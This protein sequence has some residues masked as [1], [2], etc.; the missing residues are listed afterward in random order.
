MGLKRLR[1]SLRGAFRA[2]RIWRS[3]LTLIAYLWWDA[4]EWTYS[5]GCTPS[6]ERGVSRP[7]LVG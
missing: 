5:G 6:G 4:R 3:V 2:L 1:S 7:G